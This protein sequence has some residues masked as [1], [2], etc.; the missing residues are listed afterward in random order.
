[1][2]MNQAQFARRINITSANLSKYLNGILPITQTLINRISLDCGVSRRWLID[3]SDVP[4]AK[5]ELYGLPATPGNGNR[6]VPVYDIDVTAGF[7]PLAQT[8]EQERPTGYIDLPKMHLSDNV[9]LVRVSGVSM[10]PTIIDGGF[11]AVRQVASS[12]IF[13][14]QIYVVVLEDYR[15][16]KVVRRNPDNPAKVILHSV[17]PQYD[18]MEV[19]LHKILGL[20]LV[21]AV[22]N[23]SQLC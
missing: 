11:V 2:G 20:Y 14:G 13:W 19:D 3:G 10:A 7:G 23:Y 15:M 22:I 1:M 8:F 17:N 16:V 18:D 21:E 9:R 6:A 4:F 12:E 5:P